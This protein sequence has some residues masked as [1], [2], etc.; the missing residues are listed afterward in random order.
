MLIHPSSNSQTG[1]RDRVWQVSWSHDGKYLASCG[2]DKSVIIWG[3]TKDHTY[4]EIQKIEDAHQRTIRRVGW[5]PCGKYLAL[6]CFDSTT[7]VWTKT[8][9]GIKRQRKS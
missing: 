1:H 6:A 8:Q 9:N 3:A 7:S 5:S 2:G 4:T